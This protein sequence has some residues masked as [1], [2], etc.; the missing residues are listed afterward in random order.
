M[1]YQVND[2]VLRRYPPAKYRGNR[3]RFASWWRVPYEIIE[4]NNRTTADLV[5]KPYC[6]IRNLRRIRS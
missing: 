1:T 3:H 5:D 4:P 2:Y 6:M